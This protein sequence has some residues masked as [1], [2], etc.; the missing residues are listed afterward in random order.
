MAPHYGEL[1]ADQDLPELEAQVGFVGL[2]AGSRAARLFGLLAATAVAGSIGVLVRAGHRKHSE[3]TT[4]AHTKPYGGDSMPEYSSSPYAGDEQAPPADSL[5]QFFD[6]GRASCPTCSCDCS[7]ASNPSACAAQANDGH[8]CWSCCCSGNGMYN[9]PYGGS[10][11]GSFNYNNDYDRLPASAGDEAQGT[12]GA[13]VYH[14]YHHY[15]VGDTAYMQGD[16]QQNAVQV[17]EYQGSGQYRVKYLDGSYDGPTTVSVY[18]MTAPAPSG[19][20][21]WVWIFLFGT[22]GLVALYAYFRQP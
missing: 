21:L 14:Y 13:G 3:A 1:P 19:V 10:M 15:K 5:T 11:D 16:G 7:W 2:G 22:I 12:A 4:S 20:S 18:H 9:E 17:L 6:V 8:C